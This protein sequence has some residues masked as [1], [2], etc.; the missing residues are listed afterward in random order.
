MKLAMWA[1]RLPSD[2]EI[3]AR[4]ERHRE[5]SAE[6]FK[7]TCSHKILNAILSQAVDVKNT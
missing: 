6:G 4:Q 5:A 1:K 3:P 7:T 2:D